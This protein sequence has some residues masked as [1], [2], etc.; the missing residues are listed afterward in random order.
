VPLLTTLRGAGAVQG[1]RAMQEKALTFRASRRT[2]PGQRASRR[3][4]G[5][6]SI[7]LRLGAL[8]LMTFLWR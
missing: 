3:G 8:A 6:A 1:I 4:N 2:T 7:P 5:C